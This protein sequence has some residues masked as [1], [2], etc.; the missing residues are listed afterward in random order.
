[1]CG[2]LVL[3]PIF[4]LRLEGVFNLLE[5]VALVLLRL[6]LGELFQQFR[7]ALG[8]V[9]RR[10]QLDDDMFIAACRA[11][12]DWHTHALQAEAAAALCA[13]RNLDGRFAFQRIHRHLRAQRCLREAERQFI[14]DVVALPFEDRMR[15]DRQ[16][17]IEVA[18]GAA[19]RTDF[20]FAGHTHV[21]AVIHSRRNIDHDAA[22][23]AHASLAS[24][25]GAGRSN[26]FAFAPAA[27]TDHHIDKLPEDRLLHPAN[28]TG[29]LAGR[30]ALRLRAW[31]RAAAP[32]G[33]AV[34]PAGET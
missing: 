30:A 10:H 6:D 16:T 9:A 14:H 11:M 7:L 17:D 25:G 8:E 3:I 21:D 4:S 5:D 34:L 33:R 28:F 20:A 18:R 27:V 24:A 29:A 13:W 19:A 31:L 2:G 32:A 15:F 12:H 26:H 22:I 23:V 1:M